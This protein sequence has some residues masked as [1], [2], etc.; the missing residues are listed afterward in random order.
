MVGRDALLR[1][2]PRLSRR[3]LFGALSETYRTCGTEGCRCHRGEKHGPHLYVSFRGEEGKT[4]GF[5]VPKALEKGMRDGVDAWKR[6]EEVLRELA[7]FA[8]S[9]SLLD[10]NLKT[11][12]LKSPTPRAESLQNSPLNPR[13]RIIRVRGNPS[14]SSLTT[15]GG[16]YER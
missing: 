15:K 8:A 14:Q 16:R 1:E 10:T 4:T 3:V 11:Q 7:D 2:V 9:S 5:Y 13:S 6:L 12:S